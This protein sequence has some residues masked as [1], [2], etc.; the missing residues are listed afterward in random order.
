[1]NKKKTTNYR[2]GILKYSY[3]ENLSLDLIGKEISKRP[4][5]DESMSVTNKKYNKISLANR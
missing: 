4:I 3:Q 1:M 2:P 5:L